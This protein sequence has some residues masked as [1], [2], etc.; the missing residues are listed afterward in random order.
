METAAIL[1]INSK[2]LSILF[3]KNIHYMLKKTDQNSYLD[4]DLGN[5]HIEKNK[6]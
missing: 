4:I 2:K 5:W 6:I 1:E 3:Y